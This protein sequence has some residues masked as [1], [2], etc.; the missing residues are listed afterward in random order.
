M[1]AAETT[2]SQFDDVYQYIG[3]LADSLRNWQSRVPKLPA[4]PSPEQLDA[5][6][7]LQH[8]YEIATEARAGVVDALSATIDLLGEQ[9][10]RVSEF[11]LAWLPEF[12]ALD[13][14]HKQ[15]LKELGGDRETKERERK[16]F[17]QEKRENEKTAKELRSIMG[18]LETILA[19]RE[20]LLDQLERAH[21]KHYDLRKKKYD[22]LTGLSD[23]KLRVELDHA[24]DKSRFENRVVDMLKGGASAVPVGDR[25]SL[26]H[27]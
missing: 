24:V 6:Q 13:E 22:E 8:A 1:R 26:I 4:T 25:L 9:K 21:R 18:D 27:I 7:G 20:C 12:E 11:I 16:G 15:I 2:K 10:S 23:G 17:E 3:S 19:E 14:Q 5:T